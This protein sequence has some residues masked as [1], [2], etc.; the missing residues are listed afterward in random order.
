M[1]IRYK[2]NY[3]HIDQFKLKCCIGKAGIK[4]N[5]IEGDKSTPFG[6]FTLGDL[7]FRKDRNY[8]INT[9][10]R[11]KAIKR[12]MG[13]CDDPKSNNYNRLIL[14]NKKTSVSYEKFFRRDYKYDLIIPINYNYFKPKKNRGS[15]IF[16]H[17][18]KKF[19]PTAGCI[20]LLKK[21]FLIM[22][23]LISKRTSIFIS[24]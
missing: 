3:L 7:Y 12:N 17:L 23:K 14:I 10:L 22:L 16:I 1:I 6:K 20:G 2:K 19:K 21:D 24:I 13:W 4:K 15:A 9:K 11:K 8:L 5:K 18:T